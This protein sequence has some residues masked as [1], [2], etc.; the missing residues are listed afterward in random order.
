METESNNLLLKLHKLAD[1]QGENFTTE[2]FSHVLI[3][4]IQFEPRAAVFMLDKISGSRLRIDIEQTQH[5]YLH[6]QY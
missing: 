1:R 2:V 6:K 5:Q 3:H 4:L